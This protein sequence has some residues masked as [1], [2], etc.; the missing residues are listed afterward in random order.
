[1]SKSKIDISFNVVRIPLSELREAVNIGFAAKKADIEARIGKL[2]QAFLTNEPET[3]NINFICKKIS[4]DGLALA[5]LG[6]VMHALDCCRT[7]EN[8]EILPTDLPF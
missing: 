1:M 8:I 3:H 5:K 6:N 2:Q 7:R 4:D